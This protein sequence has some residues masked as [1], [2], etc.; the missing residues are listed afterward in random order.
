VE[1][2]IRVLLIAVVVA[3]SARTVAAQTRSDPTHTTPW[4]VA[5]MAAAYAGNPPLQTERDFGDD[6]FNTGAVAIVTGR[7]ITPHLKLEVEVSA[8]GDGR[9]W[10]ETTITVPGYPSPIFYGAEHFTS[11]RSVAASLVY[12]FLD[13]QWAHPFVQVG[14]AI[15]G[16]R[17]YE[18]T[19][20][21]TFFVGPP[22]RPDSPL[23]IA[24]GESE[25]ETTVRVRLLLGGGAKLYV[26]PRVFFRTDGHAAFDRA[27]RH[28]SI[29]AGVG[30][31]F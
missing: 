6:W 1:A 30:V 28:L 21:Q 11:V 16:D 5:V 29:R 3:M 14:A 17:E 19:L 13:N 25:P 7:H 24:G 12:Q 2:A 15:D 27:L 8:T 26:T 10:V 9:R 4:D 31:D 18:R 23:A 20:P 22:P